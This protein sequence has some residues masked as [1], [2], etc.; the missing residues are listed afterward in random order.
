MIR[1]TYQKDQNDTI[2]IR[3]GHPNPCTRLKRQMAACLHIG[4]KLVSN[5]KARTPVVRRALV[6]GICSSIFGR[7]ASIR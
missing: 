7:K 6:H 3:D 4:Y 2:D 1:G 5:H